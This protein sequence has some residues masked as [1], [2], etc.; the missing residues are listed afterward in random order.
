MKALRDLAARRYREN[1]LRAIRLA[2]WRRF[3]SAFLFGVAITTLGVLT[4]STVARRA[5]QPTTSSIERG[6]D[7]E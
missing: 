1:D 4:I 2:A 5:A 3:L 7:H 6:L